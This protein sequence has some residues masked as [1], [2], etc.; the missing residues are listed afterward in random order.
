MMLHLSVAILISLFSP[1]CLAAEKPKEII[2][3][4]K[5]LAKIRLGDP[6]ESLYKAFGKPTDKLVMDPK[7]QNKFP[8]DYWITFGR[9]GVQALIADQRILTLFFHFKSRKSSTFNGVTD[10]G[11]GFPSSVRDVISSYGNPDETRKSVV[12]KFGE[13]PGA[14]EIRMNYS[15]LGVS[16]LFLD[17]ELS[18]IIVTKKK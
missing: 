1:W 18:Q 3:P 16:F 7:D 11:I 15:T 8:G 4:G 6:K 2:T 17:G 13:Y 5:G 9:S 10:K 12:S 14:Q